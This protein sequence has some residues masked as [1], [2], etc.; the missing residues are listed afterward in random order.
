[1][2]DKIIETAPAATTQA[3]S[4]PKD[5]FVLASSAPQEPETQEVAA[6]APESE[7]IIES[8]T[9]EN[10]EL[11][12]SNDL[13]NED[14]E[15]GAEGTEQPGKKKGGVQK[16]IDKLTKRNSKLSQELELTKKLL[17][18]KSGEQTQTRTE[19]TTETTTEV[20]N[21]KR[22]I[23]ANFESFEEYTEALA[24]WKVDQKFAL[25]EDND[26]KLSATAQAK[27]DADKL[28]ADHLSRFEKY[29]KENPE[30]L[31]DMEDIKSA[32]IS[33]NVQ[34]AIMDS[35]AGPQLMHELA[36]N[37]EVLEKL[38]AME[39]AKALREIGRMEAKYGSSS[40]EKVES[41]APAAEKVAA[42]VTKAPKPITTIESKAGHVKT[43]RDP[44]PYDEWSRIRAAEIKAR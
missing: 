10:E 1:M 4:A 28:K 31:E 15:A 43:T 11:E 14:L 3:A 34:F 24:D 6:A 5:D 7:T 16:R 33:L 29:G 40:S 12:V 37:P 2:Q 32:K 36:K 35:E 22:P 18:E 41:K 8:E 21:S 25:K 38:N 19:A 23:R 30:F 20:D 13:E 44:L 9:I 39:P 42:K 26:K 17:L 27:A